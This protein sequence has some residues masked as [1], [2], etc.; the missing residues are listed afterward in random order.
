[1]LQNKLI[2]NTRF[3]TSSTCILQHLS[4]AWCMFSAPF[5]PK[6]LLYFGLRTDCS[7]VYILF[8]D[9]NLDTSQPSGPRDPAPPLLS[10]A[11]EGPK[12]APFPP[13]NVPSQ[14]STS[15][16]LHRKCP[17]TGTF[18]TSSGY[19]A[20]F[21]VACLGLRTLYVAVSLLPSHLSSPSPLP[22]SHPLLTSL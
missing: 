16:R 11:D 21:S 10:S 4:S 17:H 14:L 3:L 13:K 18:L 19:L 12:M 20:S 1:M 22:S 9:Q 15:A 5:P 7:G 6:S 2:T 8:L